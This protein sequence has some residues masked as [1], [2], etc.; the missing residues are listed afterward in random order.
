M[1][2]IA[3]GGTTKN[4]PT[5]LVDSPWRVFAHTGLLCLAIA[6]LVQGL[7]GGPFWA[8]AIT[9]FSIGWSINLSFILFGNFV[10]RWLSPYIASIPLTAVGLCAG[11]VIAGLI[12]VADPLFFFIESYATLLLGVFFGI[13]GFAIFSTRGRL[14]AV[15]A[16][17]AQAAAHRERQEKLLTQTELKLLQAQIEP[18]FLFNTLSNIA[19]LIHQDPNAAEHTLLN[20]TTLL[21]AS[22]RRTREEATTLAEELEIAQAYLEIQGI[23]MQGRLNYHIDCD[24]QLSNHPLPPLLVQP[25]I[26]NAIKHGIDPQEEGGSI[27]ISAR[28]N[29]NELHIDVADTGAGIDV[30]RPTAGTGTGLKNVRE[31]LQ[32]LYGEKANLT[33]ADNQPQGMI[34]TLVLPLLSSE[35]GTTN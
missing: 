13:V 11:M 1:G 25:L 18:H 26:E 10:Q 23:R 7:F 31:R 27:D 4:A 3:S 24:L 20:L 22:L 12:I 33:L 16:E 28:V 19:G 6:L 9:S 30:N 14:I 35:E 5:S 34:A 17:L 21:R 15:Q 8:N 32:A 2:E 29:N